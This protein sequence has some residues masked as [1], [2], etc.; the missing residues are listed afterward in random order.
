[1]KGLDSESRLMSLAYMYLSADAPYV[2]ARIISNGMKSKIIER[3]VKN[4]QVVGSA[5]YQS[6]D[7]AKAVHF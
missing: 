6:R 3:S 4:L 7:Y 1:M 2:G 5:Y